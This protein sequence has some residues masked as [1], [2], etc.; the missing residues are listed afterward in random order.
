MKRIISFLFALVVLL[1]SNYSNVHARE[2][3]NKLKNND[4]IDSFNNDIKSVDKENSS[5]SISTD[6]DIF[7]DE[8]A[9]PFIAGL[10]KNAAH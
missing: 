6:K 7:G 2:I 1:F 4:S 8:Q 10:G 3:E 5:I 9:F